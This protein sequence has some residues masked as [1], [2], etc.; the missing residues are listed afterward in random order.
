MPLRTILGCGLGVLFQHPASHKQLICLGR[1]CDALRIR[2]SGNLVD[3]C[4][5]EEIDDLYRIIA[6]RGEKH[7][8]LAGR[9]MIEAS[10]HTLEW[11]RC[12]QDQW[13]GALRCGLRSRRGSGL[14]WLTCRQGKCEQHK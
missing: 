5:L 13:G 8:A 6:Q 10:L 11:K 2:H 4:S 14:L 3:A 12:R 7:F 9:K 1:K